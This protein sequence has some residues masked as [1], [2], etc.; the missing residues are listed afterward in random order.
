MKP[1]NI[2]SAVVLKNGV[3][4]IK[5]I[6]LS[7]RAGVM[8][9][10]TLFEEEFTSDAGRYTPAQSTNVYDIND[11]IAIRNQLNELIGYNENLLELKETE[12]E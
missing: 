3:S 9:G 1:V 5:A 6:E 12:D 7:S 2:E 11:I 4:V 10:F 8:F